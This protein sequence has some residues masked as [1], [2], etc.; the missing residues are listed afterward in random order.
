MPRY[1]I[2]K[3]SNYRSIDPKFF[4]KFYIYT[5][6]I[7]IKLYK[8]YK[9]IIKMW[10]WLLLKSNNFTIHLVLYNYCKDYF[11]TYIIKMV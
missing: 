1:K 8:E 5:I 9:R 4:V 3:N 11:T 10:S 6:K 2:V 7:T